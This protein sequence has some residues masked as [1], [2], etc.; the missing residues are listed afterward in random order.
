MA[1]ASKPA[2]LSQLDVVFDGTWIVAPRVD[3][4]G[5]IIGVDVYSPACG[6]P[7]G[8]LF[9]SD[10]N[11]SPWP[12]SSSFYQLDN[13]SHTVCIQRTAAMPAGAAISMIDQIANHCVTRP[14]PIGTNWDLLVS[15]EA[16]PDAWTSSGTITPQTTDSAGKSVRC[17]SGKDAPTAN[18]SST[19]T[20]SFRNV[21]GVEL[22]GAPANVQALLP[23]PWNGTGSLI[24]EDEI[25][26]I[27]TL[28]HE[29]STIFAMANLAGLDL[30]LEFPLPRKS[31][32]PP[33]TSGPIRPMMHS[34]PYC[35]HAA[36]L[37]PVT[38]P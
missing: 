17:F 29:R 10:L 38:N 33:A 9:T 23:A 1:S 25:P 24:F 31:S 21:T 11:P 34:G 22:L 6:H 14:R 2:I 4:S 18:V 36:I 30:A 5:K 19:Q 32:A 27:P 3:G 13:H 26:Y 20:L 28:Q 12:S 16:G 35:G 8:V 37:M 15:I 7:Q